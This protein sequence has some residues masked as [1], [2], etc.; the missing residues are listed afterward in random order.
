[1]RNQIKNKKQWTFK[2]TVKRFYTHIEISLVEH[3][4]HELSTI[5]RTVFGHTAYVICTKFG[6]ISIDRK[7]ASNVEQPPKWSIEI[8]IEI[9]WA[10]NV[11]EGFFL[12]LAMEMQIIKS[13]S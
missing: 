10:K 9:S 12:T 2:E 7:Y 1:M 11:A 3:Q 6:S 4:C 13:Y 8:Q 5:C